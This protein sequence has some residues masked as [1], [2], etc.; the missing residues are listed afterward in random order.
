[1]VFAE[2]SKPEV[3]EFGGGKFACFAFGNPAYATNYLINA[4]EMFLIKAESD[5]RTADPNIEDARESLLVVAKRNLDIT[6]VE[7]LPA[8]KE[9]LLSFLR[10]ES[11]R[12]LFQEGHRLFDIRR[13]GVK[14]NAYAYN[15]PN[16]NFRFKNVDL[17]NVIFPIPQDEINAGFGVVQTPDW[18]A[19]RSQ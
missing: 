14:G 19:G 11:A 15:A 1:M 2:D 3:P 8:T 16:I 5:L 9:E 4:P 10:D 18:T 6:S 13:W 17:S 7:D 12:E